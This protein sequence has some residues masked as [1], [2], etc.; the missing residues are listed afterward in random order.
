MPSIPPKALR[1][2]F[3]GFR[4]FIKLWATGRR[5]RGQF[6]DLLGLQNS[7][8]WEL[9]EK[10]TEARRTQNAEEQ[11]LRRAIRSQARLDKQQRL[12]DRLAE[13]EATID[14]SDEWRWIKRIR[15]DYVQALLSHPFEASSAR[16]LA[17]GGLGFRASLGFT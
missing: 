11:K 2:P 14:A 7:E 4:A 9:I 17:H 10:R 5:L 8:T 3:S 16:R 1:A 15:A 12:K 6:S 13:S